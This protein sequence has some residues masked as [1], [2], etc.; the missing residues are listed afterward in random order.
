MES[1]YATSRTPIE[2][3]TC[4][5]GN[6]HPPPPQLKARRKHLHFLLLRHPP[7]KTNYKNFSRIKMLKLLKGSNSQELMRVVSR[8]ETS[9][10]NP[11]A[12]PFAFHYFFFIA[13]SKEGRG[14]ENGTSCPRLSAFVSRL[15]TCVPSV[16]FWCHVKRKSHFPHALFLFSFAGRKCPGEV[17]ISFSNPRFLHFHSLLFPFC[18]FRRPHLRLHPHPAT[19]PLQFPIVIFKLLLARLQPFTVLSVHSFS[20]NRNLCSN[21]R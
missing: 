8:V 14:S 13:G 20:S 2:R 17:F 19:S 5:S 21:V 7:L 3:F 15:S 6:F 11:F 4:V 18:R 9:K 10:S 16:R 1:S 12:Q